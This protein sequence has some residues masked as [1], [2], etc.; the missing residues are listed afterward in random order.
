MAYLL[1]LD[2][3]RKIMNIGVNQL[4]KA[5]YGIETE[6]HDSEGIS[7]YGYFTS[8][9][10][11]KGSSANIARPMF[12]FKDVHGVCPAF[13]C[14]SNPLQKKEEVNPWRDVILPDQGIVF[15]NGD[16]KTPGVPPSYYPK[17]TP[18]TGNSKLESIIQFYFSHKQ[19]EREKAPPILVFEQAAHNGN[20][21]GYRRFVG[22]GIVTKWDI[23]QQF[24]ENDNVF[25]NYLFEITLIGLDNGVLNYDWINDRRNIN[26]DQ[27][28]INLKAPSKWKK[29]INEG[30]YSINHVKQIILKTA[31]ASPIKQI[32]ELKDEHFQ[33]LRKI[34]DHYESRSK[35][36][37]FEALASLAAAEFFGSR[38]KEG[39]ITQ[40]S[41]DMG[42]DF[43][44]RY[45]IEYNSSPSLPGNIMGRTSLLVVGQ[46]KCR[47]LFNNINKAE[48]ARDIARVASRLARGIIGVYV[49]TGTYKDSTQEEVSIDELPIILI[50]GRLL[51]DLILSYMLRT[52]KTINEI[53]VE[54]D[55]WYDTQQKNIPPHYILHKD[56]EY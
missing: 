5:T 51:V 4:F 29:W 34:V 53:L 35:K 55:Y 21:K 56:I 47:S 3:T 45:D 16:N 15:Y 8:N 30:S 38:Y 52:G 23:R 22:A 54:R 13:F 20:K 27:S 49:T 2:E 19:E 18:Q 36:D 46:A 9:N 11:I 17:G 26:I 10:Q 31:T 40:S 24:D 28:K 42:V 7:Y 44:G 48:S 39:W 1:E 32:H 43:V 37:K 41:G 50:N 12:W 6:E 25:S 33:I 14:H